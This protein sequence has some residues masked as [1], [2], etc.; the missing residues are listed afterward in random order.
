MWILRSASVKYLRP[1]YQGEPIE[2]SASI[3]QE[4]GGWEPVTVRTEA[5]SPGGNLLVEGS[6]KVIPLPAD[7]FKRVSKVEALPENWAALLEGT[8]E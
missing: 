5:K 4:G 6:F 3:E 2:L 8:A 1:A 7:K